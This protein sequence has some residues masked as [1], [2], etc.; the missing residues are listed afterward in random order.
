MA[1]ERREQRKQDRLDRRLRRDDK[2]MGILAAMDANRA[3]LKKTPV[4]DNTAQEENKPGTIRIESKGNVTDVIA[5][6][7]P[8]PTA[9]KDAV[10]SQLSV[11]SGQSNIPKGA[12]RSYG[13]DAT[14]SVRNAISA[15]INKGPVQNP[16]VIAFSEP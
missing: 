16:S 12:V 8:N 3:S 5:E 4:E 9:A 13:N 14:G 15:V 10:N 2:R 11:L 7:Q 6:D 1:K